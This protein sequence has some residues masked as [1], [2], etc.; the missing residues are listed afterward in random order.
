[1]KIYVVYE[2]NYVDFKTGMD[3]TLLFCGAYKSRKKAMRKA[4]ALIK[5]AKADDLF[6]DK[7]IVNKRNPFKNC[8]YVDFYHDARDQDY[9]VTT[10]GMEETKLIA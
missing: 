8:S 1:M 4:K 3:D 7:Q 5:A 6:M 9:V 2:K 10:I